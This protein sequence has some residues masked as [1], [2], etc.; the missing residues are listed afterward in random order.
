MRFDELSVTNL[1]AAQAAAGARAS[2]RSAGVRFDELSV[3]NLRAGIGGACLA[4]PARDNECGLCDSLD[5]MNRAWFYAVVAVDA[6]V[7]SGC[8]G[9]S[10]TMPGAPGR[11]ASSPLAIYAAQAPSLVP[12]AGEQGVSSVQV[13]LSDNTSAGAPPKDGQYLIYENGYNGS[14]SITSSCAAGTVADASF[15]TRVT[16]QAQGGYSFQP[17][18]IGTGPGALLDVASSGVFGPQT[19]TITVSDS[20]AHSASIVVTNH[21]LLLYPGASSVV[22]ATGSTG[23]AYALL[24]NIAPP[25]SF[26]VY[27]QGFSG[28]YALAPSTC[29]TFGATL[30]PGSGGAG[31]ILTIRATGPRSAEACVFQITDGT[32]QSAYAKA[33]YEGF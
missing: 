5:M 16:P 10:S 30:T 23:T 29:S 1:R 19:C 21:Q 2:A 20:N 32:G 11:G 4:Q 33:Y 7:L 26:L 24:A 3:T 27:E 12:A 6:V 8:G 15:E 17:G 28:T 18:P 13:S 25:M 22:P 9:G 14:Y 31:A